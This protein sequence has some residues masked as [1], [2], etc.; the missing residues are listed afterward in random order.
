MLITPF[1]A[2]I[3]RRFSLRHTSFSP[4]MLTL[5][6]I[7]PCHYFS[8]PCRRYFDPLLLPAF[9]ITLRLLSLATVIFYYWAPADILRFVA[10]NIEYGFCRR[11]L[12]LILVTLIIIRPPLS[13]RWLAD[14]KLSL[15]WCVPCRYAIIYYAITAAIRL[16]FAASL[17]PLFRLLR[18]WM[19]ATLLMPFHAAPLRHLRDDGRDTHC[20]Y[21]YAAIAL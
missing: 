5:L 21:Y 2:M 19:P 14:Y 18:C 13:L 1:A 3:I 17:L 6:L 20:H 11:L 12:K 16:S 10:F 8:P 4:A 9:V 15:R 7:T